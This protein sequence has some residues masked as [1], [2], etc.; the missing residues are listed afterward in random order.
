MNHNGKIEIR[1]AS[2]E[3]AA[4]LLAVYAPYVE[5]T[6]VSFEYETPSVETFCARVREI[7]REYPYLVCVCG[8][9][10]VGYAYAHR[11]LER[12][13]Y[14][15]NVELSVYL[16]PDFCGKGIGYALYTALIE[17]LSM[18]NVRNLY[19]LVTSPNPGSERLHQK[20]GFELSGVYHKTGYKCGGWHDVL[21]FE[22]SIA[23]EGKPLPLVLFEQ[24]DSNAV[25]AVLSSVNQKMIED[26]T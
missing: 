6:A 17:L 13:A 24:L 19:A 25:S 5:N 20:C 10:T 14:Q 16:A 11:M 3:D 21:L 4:A 2:E 15:W 22:R 9:R 8:G 23:A 12:A 1:L 7:S 18:Q 26:F